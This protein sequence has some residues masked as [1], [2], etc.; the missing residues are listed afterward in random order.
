MRIPFDKFTNNVL[1]KLGTKFQV[2]ASCPMHQD[3]NCLKIANNCQKGIDNDC[4][5][6]CEITVGIIP[7][8]IEV[9]FYGENK[10]GFINTEALSVKN[11]VRITKMDLLELIK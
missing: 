5:Q 3:H 7:I 1:N 2:S 10:K 4:H 8:K 6:F 9:V 11:F